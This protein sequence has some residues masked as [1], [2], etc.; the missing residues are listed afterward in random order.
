MAYIP[1]KTQQRIIANMG[2]YQRILKKAIDQDINESDTAMIITDML[3]ELFGYEKFS[4][5]T[6]EYSI[7]G[8]Y[9]NLAIRIDDKVKLLV[10]CKAVGIELKE[11]YVKQ[12]VDYAA[13]Q[14]IEWVVLTNGALW[15]IYRLI[16]A[17]PKD[18]ELVSEFNFLDIRG[19][20]KSDQ[21]LLFC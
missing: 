6:S 17:K 7:R 18:K 3:S 19:K 12:A 14:G 20:N 13:N 2:K 8:T 11:N 10:E 4:E 15:R 1:L 16:F 5:I 9:C 21:E